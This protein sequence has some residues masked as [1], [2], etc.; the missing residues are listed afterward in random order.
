MS[1]PATLAAAAALP[2][3]DARG[4][5]LSYIISCL[6]SILE[7]RL[8]A[9]EAAASAA[10]TAASAKGRFEV[11]DDHAW[12]LLNGMLVFFL[13]AGF[14]AL[15][16]GCVRAKNLRNVLM[17]NVID[18]ALGSIAWYLVGY[19]IAYGGSADAG[20]AFVGVG[21]YAISAAGGTSFGGGDS[22]AFWFFQWAFSATCATIVSGAVA[23]RISFEAYLVYSFLSSAWVYPV[24]VHWVW[25]PTGWLSAFRPANLAKLGGSG[26]LD[27]AGGGVVHMVGGFSA[28][29]AAILVGPRLG[30]FD[31]QTR[32]PNAVPQY[33]AMWQTTGVFILWTGF[34]AFNCGST[35]LLHGAD[36]TS[37]I[38]VVAGRVAVVT[39]LAAGTGACT[40]L[41]ISKLFMKVWDLGTMN[42]CILAG[43]VVSTSGCAVIE[44]WAGIVAGFVASWAYFGASKLVL[45]AKVDDVVDAFAVHGCSGM[46]ALVTVAWFAKPEHVVEVYGAALDGHKG[47]FYGG[48]AM[49][50]V[51][52]LGVVVIAAWALCNTAA[53]FLAAK[54]TLAIRVPPWMESEGMDRSKH[55]GLS[56]QFQEILEKAEADREG[57]THGGLLVAPAAPD[58]RL[59]GN[60]VVVPINGP[61]DARATPGA[62]GAA[63]KYAVDAEAGDGAGAHSHAQ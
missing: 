23:E 4:T 31:P 6:S 8:S 22:Y 25:S 37:R 3:I 35:L 53:V 15:T 21:D 33:S 13:Q 50:G 59:S 42:N 43:L 7:E 34:Y 41:L 60:A 57:S 28:L 11:E 17:K 16:A 51:Q 54:C 30:R 5:V 2:T 63:A 19:G 61:P 9:V 24:V 36:A 40:G 18:A 45:R 55:G 29:A 32:R 58:R 20:N 46:L 39:T 47:I 38:T 49:V 48:S 56:E 62:A 44:P 26:L 27:F 10:Q 12:L 14:C 52:F 1:C